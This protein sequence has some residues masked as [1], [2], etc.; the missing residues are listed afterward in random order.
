MSTSPP[1]ITDRREVA[2]SRLFRAEAV[3]LTFTNGEKRTFERLK[4]TQGHGAVMVVAL[5]D[6]EHFLLI[7]EYAAGFERY[8][9]GLPKGSVDPGEDPISA[10]NR[11]LKEECGYG[12]H[13]ITPLKEMSIAPNYMAHHLT[14]MLASNLYPASLPGDEP[15]PLEVVRYRWDALDQ[16]LERDDFHEARSIAGLYLARDYLR[17]NHDGSADLRGS[18]LPW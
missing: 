16:L 11:E 18:V 1:V 14:L 5:V 17:S 3:D 9:L 8:L 10:A 6:A 15:E 13:N 7:R 4:G 12:A 2:R